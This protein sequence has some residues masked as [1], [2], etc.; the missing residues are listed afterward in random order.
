[1]IARD[2]SLLD[3]KHYKNYDAAEVSFGP[4]ARALSYKKHE[5]V[6]LLLTSGLPHLDEA[7]NYIGRISAGGSNKTIYLGSAAQIAAR[8]GDW[9][10]LQILL[11]HSN[12]KVSAKYQGPLPSRDWEPLPSVIECVRS[13]MQ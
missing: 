8:K 4:I 6:R 13:A 9:Q 12:V 5:S 7:V 11:K 10:G 2:P 3:P 1:M